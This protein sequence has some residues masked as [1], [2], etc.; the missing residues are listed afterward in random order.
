MKSLGHS[1]LHCKFKANLAYM[2]SILSSRAFRILGLILRSRS[3][4][5]AFEVMFWQETRLY[6][7]HASAGES[8]VL[9]GNI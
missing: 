5:E 7:R 6:L 4:V 1:L 3:R 2:R 8:K 9:I